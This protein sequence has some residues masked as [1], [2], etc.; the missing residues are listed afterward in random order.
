[1]S[2][3]K[4][5]VYE[6]GVVDPGVPV[7]N[8]TQSFWASSPHLLSNHKSPWP[9]AVV[10]LA[11]IGSGI[12]GTSLAHHVLAKNPALNIVLLEARSLC[13]GATARNGGHIKTMSFAVWEHHKQTFGVDEAIRI[14]AFEQ[15]HLES[16]TAAIK[17]NSLDCD[18]VETQGIDAYFDQKTF[19]KAVAALDDMRR[20]APSL[21]AKYT[22][23]NDRQV[24]QR[25]L[26]LSDRCVGAISVPAASVWP[27]KMVTGLLAKMVESGRLNVQTDTVVEAIR[28]QPGDAFAMISTNRGQIRAQKVVHATNGWMGHLLPELRPFISPVRGNVVRYDSVTKGQDSTQETSPLRLDSKYS[29]W[30]RYAEKDYDYLIQRQNGDIVVGRANTGRRATG[31]DSQTD[32][33]PMAHLH[34]FGAHVVSSAVSGP[35]AHI[36]HEWSGILGFTQDTMPFVGSLERFPGRQRQWVCGGYHGIGMVKAWRSGEIMAGMLLGEGIGDKCPR[37]MLISDARMRD[38][39]RSLEVKA[40]L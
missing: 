37:S 23:L 26:N 35:S 7:K 8:P 19:D 13:S 14:A 5:G 28:D 29:Y 27:Y 6:A 31:D 34:G 21:A 24:L 9:E 38:L 30:L 10:D 22:V 32:L 20:H 15:S 39:E 11:I 1:M 2:T 17:A 4:E 40:K 12:S 18:L 33:P 25:D 3:S 36:T 16:M